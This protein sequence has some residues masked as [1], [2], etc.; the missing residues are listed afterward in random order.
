MHHFPE[1]KHV[2]EAGNFVDG[3]SAEAAYIV[4]PNDPAA[5]EFVEQLKNHH[6]AEQNKRKPKAEIIEP[7]IG[8]P[9]IIVPASA[10]TQNAGIVTAPTN[11]PVIEDKVIRV[12][13]ADEDEVPPE[14][15]AAKAKPKK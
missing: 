4:N 2:D 1:L 11:A 8:E 6:E 14:L 7:Q 5:D 15:R 10:P 9:Q 12:G 3:E 13:A